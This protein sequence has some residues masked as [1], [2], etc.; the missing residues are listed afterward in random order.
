VKIL[1][2]SSATDVGGAER[3]L[4]ELALAGPPRGQLVG[5]VAPSGTFDPELRAA[6]CVR[7]PMPR[8]DRSPAAVA[9]QALAAARAARR[10]APDVIHAHNVK[11]TAVA[12]AA[13]TARRAPVLATFHG[14]TP[15]EFPAAARVLCRADAVACVSDDLAGRLTDAGVA[16][17]LLEVVVNGVP[18]IPAPAPELR[19]RLD[20]EL[21][22][23]A[24][25]SGVVA[26]VGRLAP[27]KA[28][29][30]FLAAAVAV[31][32]AR[33]GVRFLIVGDGER[34]AELEGISTGLGLGDAVVFTGSRPDAR[35]LIAR[36][37]V[38]VFSS[39]WEGLS[40]AALESLAAGTPVVST[41]VAGMSELLG[42]GAGTMTATPDPDELAAAILA[43]L[44][45]PAAAAAMGRRGRELVERRYGVGR[46]ADAYAAI[47]AR[48]A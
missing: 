7:F 41:P 12:L 13:R 15:E 30:R 24:D 28:H 1:H 37:D 22:L 38:L 2:V 5:A 8:A 35:D 21:G 34:R 42:T 43:V 46:M 3:V 14:V 16:E 20:A 23:P 47:Y 32:D 19:A 10:M 39:H 33:P 25:D 26:I 11:A 44:A 29:E 17:G 45:D 9:R 36:A 40:I 31:R 48:L 18:L 27:Q 6:G 4:V